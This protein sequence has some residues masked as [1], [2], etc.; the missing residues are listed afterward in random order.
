MLK[1]SAQKK[2]DNERYEGYA[3][4]LIDELSKLLHFKYIFKEVKDKAYGSWDEK[5]GQWNGMIKELIDEEADLAIGDLTITSQRET[6]VD[7]TLPFMNTGISILFRKPTTK[8]T[9]LFSFLSPFS[10]VVWVYVVGAYVGVSVIL[11]VVGRLSP[12]EWDNPHPCRQD[13]QVLENDF[14]L[15]N[16]FWFTIGSLM[17]QGS[18]LAPK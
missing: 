1:G 6:A 8:V 18:D 3:V 10:M 17:Q 16:S 2:T 5:S 11:F 9:T 4:D 15:L 7:F 14:S 13:D 12:Y